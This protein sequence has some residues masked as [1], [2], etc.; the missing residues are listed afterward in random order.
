MNLFQYWSSH[1]G[2]K[3]SNNLSIDSHFPEMLLW[4]VRDTLHFYNKFDKFFF[5]GNFVRFDESGEGIVIIS[6]N[7]WG[8]VEKNTN[9]YVRHP[10]SPEIRWKAL[11]SNTSSLKRCAFHMLFPK[12]MV[13]PHKYLVKN[14]ILKEFGVP[15]DYY[16]IGKKSAGF[17]RKNLIVHNV[18]F[19]ERIRVSMTS[20]NEKN[21]FEQMAEEAKRIW[22][23]KYGE[24]DLKK[25]DKELS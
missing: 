17:R 8:W 4:E 14:R 21:R 13:S 23:D 15:D 5:K 20:G 22:S 2:R 11:M 1:F 25:F 16:I 7:E 3:D 9:S 18:S 10:D 19:S 12:K 24:E 6:S